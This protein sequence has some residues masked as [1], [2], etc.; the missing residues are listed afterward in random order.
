MVEKV[1]AGKVNWNTDSVVPDV[2]K[3]D[4]IYFI[5]ATSKAK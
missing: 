1:D 3:A 2:L 4:K 5:H